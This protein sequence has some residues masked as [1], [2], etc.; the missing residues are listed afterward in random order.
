MTTEQIHESI[1]KGNFSQNCK[2]PELVETHIS[3][4]ILCN[5][6]VYKIKKP[7][8]YSFLDFST[9]EKRK[10]YCER[11][12]ELNKRLSDH[13]Y[14]DVQS[15]KNVSGSFKIGGKEG[16]VIDYAVK[17]RKIDRQ[18]QMDALLLN[19]KVTGSDIEKLAEKIAAFHTNTSI[20][21]QK[22]FLDVQ[23]QFG[24]LE[25]ERIWGKV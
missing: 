11:E 10:Y 16:E 22:D 5:D 12:V 20:I 9:L 4:V 6:Y 8:L 13:M 18:R 3:W 25:K 17:M 14:I 21:Y 24:D 15:V 7:I 1:L 2:Q 23:N 19:N